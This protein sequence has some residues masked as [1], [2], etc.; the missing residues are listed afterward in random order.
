[1]QENDDIRSVLPSQGL[2]EEIARTGHVFT[3]PGLL[4]LAQR[5]APDQKTRLALL[6]ALAEGVPTLTAHADGTGVTAAFAVLF[7]FTGA[8]KDAIIN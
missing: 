2:R 1:M 5:Y 7:P 8:A 4:K 6:T 3:P